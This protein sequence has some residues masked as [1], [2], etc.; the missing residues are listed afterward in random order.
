MWSTRRKIDIFSKE[1]LPPQGLAVGVSAGHGTGRPALS[2]ET[3]SS[4]ACLWPYW[5]WKPRSAAGALITA[6]T[7]LEQGKRCICCARSHRCAGQCRVQPPDPGT[8]RPGGT[9]L[10]DLLRSMNIFFREN[11]EQSGLHRR[12]IWGIRPAHRRKTPVLPG[13]LWT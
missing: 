7:A 2:T 13:R 5:W 1:T 6:A 10:Q 3:A 9:E 12:R 4:Q 11:S 8:E